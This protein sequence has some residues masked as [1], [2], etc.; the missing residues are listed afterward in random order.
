MA[1]AT[2]V[3]RPTRWTYLGA[4]RLVT[5]LIGSMK[6]RCPFSSSNAATVRAAFDP[7]T[8]ACAGYPFLT[9]NMLLF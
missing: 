6:K 9:Q 5:G 7:W 3:L 8:S 1:A 2:P 4:R